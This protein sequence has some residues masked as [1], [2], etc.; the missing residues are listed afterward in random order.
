MTVARNKTT[1]VCTFVSLQDVV[2]GVRRVRS[3]GPWSN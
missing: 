2:V 1:S 3:D